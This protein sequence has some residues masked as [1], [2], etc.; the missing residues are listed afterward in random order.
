MRIL[1][2]LNQI[3]QALA[4]TTR[5]DYLILNAGIMAL[6]SRE[7]SHNGAFEKQIG[8]N[9]FGHFYLM[10]L[11]RNRMETQTYSQPTSSTP[12]APPAFSR[13]VVLTSTAHTMGS[14]DPTD[15]H[16]NKH[17]TYSGWV[18]YGQSKLANLLFAKEL[19]DQ[20]YVAHKPIAVMAVHPG[21]IQTNLWRSTGVA[22]GVGAWVLSH[23]ISDK[24]I[25]QVG[26]CHMLHIF[27]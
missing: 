24:T 21:V 13:V 1:T 12:Q 7:T 27:I 18:S 6:P 20:V 23:F 4:D 16:F 25:P 5:I 14:V 9:H 8:V 10:K 11:L 22:S 3:Y 2:Y 17:R 19:A 15:L 26:S